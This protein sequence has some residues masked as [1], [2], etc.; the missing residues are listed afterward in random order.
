[1]I[2]LMILTVM[3]T[4]VSGGAY[5]S[6]KPES[7]ANNGSWSGYT[8]TENKQKVCYM[9]GSPEK[10]E[11]D[12][13]K[14]GDVFLFITH[15]PGSNVFDDLYFDLGY[16]VK[17]NGEATVTVGKTSFSLVGDK[18]HVFSA[19]RKQDKKIISALKQGDTL[20]IKSVSQKGTKSVDTFDLKG[21]VKTY[22]AIS[23]AC[24]K[25]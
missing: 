13:K 7:L 8:F 25:P 12:Y 16:P 23:K 14:R 3:V 17:K 5:A 1:M 19:D 22:Q 2:R 24:K 11:G 20:V 21:F 18:T 15:Y 9:T 10:S 4:L 6:S